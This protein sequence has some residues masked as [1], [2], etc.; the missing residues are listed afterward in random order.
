[1]TQAN[2]LPPGA[3]MPIFGGSTGGLL[4]AAE[5]EEKYLITWSTAEERVFEMP[6]GGAATMVAGTNALYMARKE[7]CHALHRQLVAQFKIRDSKIFL[8]T[9]DG[10]QTLVYPMDGVVSEKVNPGRVQVGGMPRKIGENP[11]QAP[12]KFTGKQP[13][14]P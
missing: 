3:S 6:T 14:D 2:G 12:L 7:Q 9:P 13:Y 11:S 5:T 1:M 4:R 8:V 10:E